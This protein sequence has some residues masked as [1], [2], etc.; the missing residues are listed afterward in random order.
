MN[1]PDE[2]LSPVQ[3][4]IGQYIDHGRNFLDEGTPNGVDKFLNLVLAGRLYRDDD[5]C[6]V[7]INARQGAIVPTLDDCNITVDFDS[8][9]SIAPNIPLS[10]T[11]EEVVGDAGHD[12]STV[13]VTTVRTRCTTVGHR[14]QELTSV[15]DDLVRVLA[16]DM[17]N[18]A[19]TAGIFLV[20]VIV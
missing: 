4:G 15:G 17:T 16:L 5:E 19:Y 6:R 18:E 10:L 1:F 8:L 2:F 3:M 7:L 11:L 13:T 12:T 14:A 9:Q 20:L